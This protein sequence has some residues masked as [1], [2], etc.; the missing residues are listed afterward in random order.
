MAVVF[1]GLQIIKKFYILQGNPMNLTLPDTIIDIQIMTDKVEKG[2]K[3]ICDLQ[4]LDFPKKLSHKN[5]QFLKKEIINILCTYRLDWTISEQSSLNERLS[6][7]VGCW[8]CKNLVNSKYKH[9]ATRSSGKEV[10]KNMC[11]L[12]STKELDSNKKSWIRSRLEGIKLDSV[13][14]IENFVNKYTLLINELKEVKGD[15]TQSDLLTKIRKAT[16]AS[17]TMQANSTQIDNTLIAEVSKLTK[18]LGKIFVDLLGPKIY[19]QRVK[20]TNEMK[21]QRVGSADKGTIL[22]NYLDK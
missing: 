15:D 11:N 14:N 5:W 3:T 19:I 17:P 12:F 18:V 10:W 16:H 9:L 6:N 20:S 8:I 2:L 1:N 22:S 13:A 7:S 21:G 4:K